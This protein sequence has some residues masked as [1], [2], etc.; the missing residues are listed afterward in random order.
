MRRF[1]SFRLAAQEAA[2]SRLY[3][4]IHYKAAVE[5]GVEQGIRV[6]NLVNS[7]LEFLK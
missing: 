2:V 6:G 5:V 4:S 1:K 3:G 7:K